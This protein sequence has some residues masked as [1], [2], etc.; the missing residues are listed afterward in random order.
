MSSVKGTDLWAG[1][2][3]SG[4]S[5]GGIPGGPSYS[6]SHALPEHTAP[7]EPASVQ[8]GYNSR[9]DGRKV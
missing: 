9:I 1:V 8:G 3:L 6:D 7:I 4:V 5:F 2:P